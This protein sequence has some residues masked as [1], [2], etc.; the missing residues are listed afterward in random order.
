SCSEQALDFLEQII[1]DAYECAFANVM[2]VEDR[3]SRALLCESIV[4]MSKRNGAAVDRKWFSEKGDVC[5]FAFGADLNCSL[6]I[7]VCLRPCIQQDKL[8]SD[9]TKVRITGA[10]HNIIAA[11]PSV[12]L[13]WNLEQFKE[14]SSNVLF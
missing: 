11:V 12:K 10:E 13:P 8:R 7:K 2:H 6:H 4:T 5:T 3:L 9:F 14:L 1:T